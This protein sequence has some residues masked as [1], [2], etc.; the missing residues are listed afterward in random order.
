MTGLVQTVCGP[1][2][3]TRLGATLMH[4]HLGALQ[5]GG[6]ASGGA[7][8][9]AERALVRLS[10][11]GIQT[12]VDL[13]TAEGRAGS[14][15]DVLSLRDLSERSNFHIV[16]ASAFYK[17]PYYPDWVLDADTDTLADFHVRE[18]REGIDGTNI[19]AGMYGEVGSSLHR[20]TPNEEKAFRAI[21]RAHRTTGLAISTHCTLGTM[22]LEQ[23]AIFKDEGVELDRVVIGHLDLAPDLSYLAAVLASGVTIGFDTI[24]KEWFDYTVPNSEGA[25]E[26]AYVKW[27]YYRGDEQRLDA[28]S[29]LVQKGYASQI[30]L[31]LDLSGYETYLNRSTIGTWGY[32]Y[33]HQIFLPALRARGVSDDAI[34]QMMRGNPTRILS[35]PAG[36]S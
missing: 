12:I 20:I 17:D 18:A 6:W 19:R 16:A 36:G 15:R 5:P 9:A 24:G 22:A 29:W 30:I 21:A 35:V 10:E 13:T 14:G 32:A 25:G 3:R 26:G 8:E 7:A 2:D 23:I 11:F 1:I 4:E 27:T 33:I 34:Q 28:L 31:S